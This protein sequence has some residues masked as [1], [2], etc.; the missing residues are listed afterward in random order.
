MLSATP[1]QAHPASD[2]EIFQSIA[3]FMKRTISCQ[4]DLDT[5]S[6]L[7]YSPDIN[8]LVV[9]FGFATIDKHYLSQW[10]LISIFEAC[11]AFGIEMFLVPRQLK[12]LQGETSLTHFYKG[13]LNRFGEFANLAKECAIYLIDS[14]DAD[15]IEERRCEHPEFMS[16][17]LV[18]MD[19]LI[20]DIK[21]E[22]DKYKDISVTDSEYTG[23]VLEN[24][25][26]ATFGVSLRISADNPPS[27]EMY[28]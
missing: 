27:E 6:H 24:R 23:C 17:I 15:L 14:A 25:P 1:Q 5:L 9:E 2:T 13:F 18:D 10:T 4:W 20:K 12:I 21:H 8:D 16:R 22:C 3:S 26:D 28:E 11:D 19:E 7:T